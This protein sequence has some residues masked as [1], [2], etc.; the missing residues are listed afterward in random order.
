MQEAEWLY[1]ISAADALAHPERVLEQCSGWR[2][3]LVSGALGA[4]G[5]GN[6]G[7]GVGRLVVGRTCEGRTIW[8]LI[9]V[10][11]CAF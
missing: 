9:W 2:G 5:G 10:P 6:G 11:G 8:Q 1:G 4:C 7:G 3:V